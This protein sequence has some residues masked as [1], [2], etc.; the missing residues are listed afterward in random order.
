MK[1]RTGFV[2]NSSSSS[3]TIVMTT[4]QEKEWMDKLNVYEIQLIENSYL[5]RTQQKLGDIDVVVFGGSTG[6]YSLYEEWEYDLIPEDADLSTEELGDKYNIDFY[7][8]EIWMSAE[9]KLPENV[10]YSDIDM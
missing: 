9:E 6:N 3:F 5:E 1:I 10:V 7:P 4:E 2:S 8:S